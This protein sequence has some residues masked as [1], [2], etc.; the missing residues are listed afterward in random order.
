[1]NLEE[2]NL[3]SNYQKNEVK[4]FLERFDLR[5][6]ENIDYTIVIRENE[7]IVATASKSK[8]IIKCFAVDESM[9]GF[10]ITNTLV[11]NILN[12]IFGE[13][14]FHAFLFTKPK[15]LNIFE[16]VGFSLV[17]KTEKVALLEIGTQNIKKTIDEII[18]DNDIDI[19]KKRAMIVMNANPFT[20]GHRYLLQRASSENEEVLVF[21]VEED[22]SCFPFKDRLELVKNGAKDLKN[23]K[24]IK[25]TNYIISSATFPNYFLRKEDDFL[26]EY[27]KLDV[28]ITATQF[29]K[30][31][32]I[33]RRYVGS[34]PYCKVTNKY[35]E[36][37]K[38]ILE[39]YGVEFIMVERKSDDNGAISASKVREFIKSENFGEMDKLLPESTIE[40]L[41]TD[42]GKKICEK[43]KTTD[44]VH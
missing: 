1:M 14:S 29:C 36:I 10:G 42:E 4:R 20:L 33:N 9:Q 13:G 43:I 39:K 6:D 21:V 26:A 18:K 37:M 34:E 44:S 24:V 35:N 28:T 31:L 32:N 27:I 8:D 11:T 19:S 5:F 23:V 3:K 30:K 15:N 17:A 41:K 22:K 12:R 16:N 38:E 40:F 7:E 2:V 25:G